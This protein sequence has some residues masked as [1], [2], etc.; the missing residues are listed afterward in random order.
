M[1]GN[2]DKGFKMDMELILNF[3]QP[4]G[5]IYTSLHLLLIMQLSDRFLNATRINSIKAHLRWRF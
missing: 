3:T 2:V 1:L 5:P 4:Y